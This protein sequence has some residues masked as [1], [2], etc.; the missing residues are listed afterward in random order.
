MSKSKSIDELAYGNFQKKQEFMEKMKNEIIKKELS[1]LKQPQ[2]NRNIEISSKL[3]LNLP[4]KEYIKNLEIKNLTKQEKIQNSKEKKILEE[5]QN[6]S[7]KPETI[8]LN[9]NIIRKK[10]VDKKQYNDNLS[11]SYIKINGKN[12]ENYNRIQNSD[13]PKPKTQK[14]QKIF[15]ESKIK[16]PSDKKCEN[17]K[18]LTVFEE[19]I[20]KIKEE[21]RSLL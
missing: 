3:G 8:A 16:E 5:L 12:K 17:E 4:T 10:I 11:N 18:K 19:S 2:I 14:Y 20:L 21:I 1:Q 9:K 6:C 7:Y 15:E 13:F